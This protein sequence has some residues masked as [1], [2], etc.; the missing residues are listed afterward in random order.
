MSGIASRLLPPVAEDYGWRLAFVA[1]IVA[2]PLGVRWATGAPIEQAV[3]SNAVLMV[4]AGLLVGFGSVLG[5][6]CT[7][8][9]GVCGIS[10]LSARSIIATLIFMTTGFLTVFIGRH[11]LGA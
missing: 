4:T 2:A 8:G 10:R 3:S 1:G 11:V 7:S 9:H 6:G 5:S